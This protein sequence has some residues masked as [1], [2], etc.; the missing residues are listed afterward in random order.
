[1]K[2]WLWFLVIVFVIVGLWF[3]YWFWKKSWTG[4]TGWSVLLW[5]EKKLINNYD[6]F[7]DE[8]TLPESE[9]E[10]TLPE[11]TLQTGIHIYYLSFAELKDFFTNGDGIVY[12]GFPECPRCRRMLP[13]LSQVAKDSNQAI[14]YYNPKDIRNVMVMDESGNLV[15]EKE[16]TPEYQFILDTMGDRLPAYSGLWD[17][18]IKRL[19]VPFLVFVKE[20]QI[21]AHHLNVLDDYTDPYTPLTEEQQTR[22]YK[23]LS[24]YVTKIQPI[25]TSEDTETCDISETAC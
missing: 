21:Q 20:G 25:N 1:M 17:D 7:V 14:Y 8:Y 3:L 10:S 6:R 16:T 13:I 12:F 24:D 11:V 4:N 15:I 5:W 2:K 23:T 22:L 18:T 19:Y 9:E